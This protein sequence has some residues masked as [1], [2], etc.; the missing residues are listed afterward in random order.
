ME[1]KNG[2]CTTVSQ[3]LGLKVICIICTHI[4][5]TFLGTSHRT[6]PS[7]AGTWENVVPTWA[8]IFQKQ[9]YNARDAQESGDQLNISYMAHPPGQPIPAKAH[10]NFSLNT[11]YIYLLPEEP[12]SL[13]TPDLKILDLKIKSSL[14]YQVWM[15]PFMVW[16]HLI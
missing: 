15:C 8:A 10:Q 13:Q 3:S 5:S 1:K 6:P 9:A 16:E 12:E 2:D 4:M 11:D 14:L 7:H